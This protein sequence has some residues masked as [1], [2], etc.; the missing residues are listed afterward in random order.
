M[1]FPADL[2]AAGQ[3]LVIALGGRW[4]QDRGMC[5][6]PAHDDR[7]ASLSVRIGERTLLFKCFAGCETSAV[8]AA[9]RAEHRVVPRQERKQPVFAAPHA[10]SLV[11]A[12]WGE[13][14]PLQQTIG[15]DYLRSRN[16]FVHPP[17]LRFHPRTPLGRGR[18]VE[19]RPAILAAV[20]GDRGLTALQR[21]FLRLMAS[22]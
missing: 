11:R 9:L 19:K 16:L 18:A 8:L 13:A 20:A 10:G 7:V 5:R 21:I 4:Y 3:Q 6:C 22:G 12:L 15:A 17:A 2:A 1:A 14:F